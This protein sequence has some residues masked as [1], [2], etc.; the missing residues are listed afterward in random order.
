MTYR[1]VY[2]MRLKDSNIDNDLYKQTVGYGKLLEPDRVSHIFLSFG[3]TLSA[4]LFL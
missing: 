1:K 3:T 2:F 4:T